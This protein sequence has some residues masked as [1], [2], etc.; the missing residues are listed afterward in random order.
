VVHR[1]TLSSGKN[2]KRENENYTT[3]GDKI[4]SAGTKTKT[5]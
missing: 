3:L 1:A 2:K 5:I 4:V